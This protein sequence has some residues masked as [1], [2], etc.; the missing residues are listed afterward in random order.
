MKLAVDQKRVEA[1]VARY[2]ARFV[3][4]DEYD[5]ARA[6]PVSIPMP[7]ED[8]QVEAV[9]LYC[10][11]G[12]SLLRFI[13]ANRSNA[14]HVIFALLGFTAEQFLAADEVVTAEFGVL[15]TEVPPPSVD[16]GVT[17]DDCG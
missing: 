5:V 3:K 2:G 6:T 11:D 13:R 17:E 7:C 10:L 9:D 8:K 12:P 16:Q 1:Y 14:E 4:R 15:A